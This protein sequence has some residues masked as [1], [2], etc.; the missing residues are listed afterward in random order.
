MNVENQTFLDAINQYGGPFKKGVL[1]A[2]KEF[3]GISIV[4]EEYPAGLAGDRTAIDIVAV[5]EHGNCICY[6]TIE[7]KRALA[8]FKKWVFFTETA[9]KSFKV[10]R[11]I[12]GTTSIS[13]GSHWAWLPDINMCSDAC[14]VKE[15]A[16]GKLLK[17]SPDPIYKAATQ[18]SLGY[19]SFLQERTPDAPPPKTDFSPRDMVVIPLIVTTAELLLSDE[20]GSGV[21]MDTGL[22]DLKAPASVPWVGYRFPCHPTTNDRAIDSR[23][24][25]PTASYT[26][27]CIGIDSTMA[28]SY[29]ETIFVVQA[30]QLKAFVNGPL[31]VILNHIM[32]FMTAKRKEAQP[33]S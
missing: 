6:L 17:A 31:F 32:K 23:I 24:I 22:C 3:D 33:C 7:C 1:N 20:D 27:A 9:T 12:S 19:L 4:A 8:P 10:G 2:L 13:A 18:A 25:N 16:N 11:G 5:I 26:A 21:N 15:D 30:N 29:K 14:E 28:D